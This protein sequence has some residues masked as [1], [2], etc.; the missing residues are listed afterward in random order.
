MEIK[1]GIIHFLIFIGGL[2]VFIYGMKLMSEGLQK[3]TGRGLR[4]LFSYL[5]TNPFLG[6][7]TGFIITG[8]IQS[9]SASTVMVVSLVNTSLVSLTQSVGLILGANIGTTITSWIISMVGF[10]VQTVNIALI[11]MGFALPM[12]FSK[13]NNWRS[14]AEFLVGFSFMLLGLSFM[15]DAVPDLSQQAKILSFLQFYQVTISSTLL[16]VFLGFILTVIVQSSSV[17]I[18]MVQILAAQGFIPLEFAVAMLLGANVGTTVTTNIAAIV[19]SR[20]A[21]RAARIHTLVNVL[22]VVWAIFVMNYLLKGVNL[23]CLNVLDLPYSIFSKIPA[24]RGAIM[25]FALATF[26]TGFNLLNA[27]V[28]IWFIP[29]LVKLSNYLVAKKESIFEV[30]KMNRNFIIEIPELEVLEAKNDLLRLTKMTKG[31]FNKVHGAF[32]HQHVERQFLDAIN[33]DFQHIKALKRIWSII[34][35]KCTKNIQV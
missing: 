13:I 27:L 3:I 26:H 19:A 2:G 28:L 31:I 8:L 4:K 32:L 20:N 17:S 14:T 29:L 1:S 23:F 35:L 24:E 6:L 15:K 30:T 10:E 22:G 5:T 12:I 18:G 16:A 25:P 7:A 9:S 21:K 11:I 34:F 33:R